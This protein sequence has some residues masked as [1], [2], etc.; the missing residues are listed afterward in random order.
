[1]IPATKTCSRCGT[2]QP[3]TAFR[4]TTNRLGNRVLRSACKACEAAYKPA[5][6]RAW[7]VNKKLVMAKAA[8][9]DACE[10][11]SHC[12]VTGATCKAFDLFVETG[13]VNFAKRWRMPHGLQ[14]AA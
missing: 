12:K 4:A 13:Q 11:A 1:M 5:Y 8:P 7:R 14:V 2:T 9:C 3:A 10:Y 6:E